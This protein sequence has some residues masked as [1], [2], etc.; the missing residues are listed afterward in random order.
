MGIAVAPIAADQRSTRCRI[1]GRTAPPGARLCG[2][3]VAAVKRARQVPTISSQFLPLT[4]LRPT[5]AS[6]NRAMP[7]RS[8][9][10]LD[11]RS[12]LPATAGGWGVI[13][14]FAIFGVA[15]CVTAYFAVQEIDDTAGQIGLT[16]PAPVGRRPQMR[17]AS[18]RRTPRATR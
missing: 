15:V 1:C 17:T 13:V 18:W 9:P 2:Q 8:R 6:A 7:R 11:L 5:S 16:S 10:R 3:C 14:A 12:W 4:T